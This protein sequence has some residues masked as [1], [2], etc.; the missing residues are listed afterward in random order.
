MANDTIKTRIR[1]KN[2]TE[3]N[4]N[5]AVLS[6]DSDKGTKESGNSFIPLKGEVIVYS[7][8]K[9]NDVLP[10]GRSAPLPFS[11]FKVGDGVT[12]VA[13]LP[14]SG[15][16]TAEKVN[17]TLTLPNN[18]SYDGSEDVDFSSAISDPTV[19]YV[20]NTPNNKSYLMG[21]N[22][23]P[24]STITPRT[25]NGDTKVYLTGISGELSSM[26]YSLNDGAGTPQEKVYIYWNAVDQSIDFI[27]SSGGN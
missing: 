14:F 6:T 22:N 8:E 26:R 2:D 21:C 17:H 7:A 18:I 13:D 3:A 11:R 23:E 15:A 20:L 9:N 25:A 19:N 24:S 1:L 27:F 4:W 16:A 12:N 5:S 10:A